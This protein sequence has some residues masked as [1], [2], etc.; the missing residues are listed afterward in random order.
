MRV[1]LIVLFSL[2]LSASEIKTVTGISE[3]WKDATHK[4]C[5]GFY[6][7]IIKEVYA[8][9][10]IKLNCK[11][12]PYERG[13]KL[14]QVKKIDFWVGS[15]MS[16]EDFAR[17][18][19]TAFD[20]DMVSVLYDSTKNDFKKI[21]DLK[22]KKIGWVR[23][24]DYN[25]YIDFPLNYKELST[26]SSGIKMVKLGRLDYFIDNK[27]DLENALKKLN[28]K[29]GN[30]KMKKIMDLKLYLGFSDTEKSISL[31]KIWDKNIK[32]LH[33]SGKLKKIYDKADYTEFYPF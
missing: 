14:T 4:N 7:E 29:N 1:F 33:N 11:I 25:E 28:L 13:I 31:I 21:E 8:L 15:Y 24:Y 27:G 16:E 20:A 2:C 22:S 5:K 12:A 19:K 17:Y 10:N 18:P 30:I 23:G 3:E 26:R 32:K 9:E 6:W